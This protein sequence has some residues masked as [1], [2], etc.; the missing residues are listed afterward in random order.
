MKNRKRAIELA[1]TESQ[2]QTR[3]TE[4]PSSVDPTTTKRAW[5]AIGAAAGSALLATIVGPMVAA[6]GD[7]GLNLD[8]PAA[9]DDTAVLTGGPDQNVIYLQPGEQAPAGAPVVRLDP[10]TVVASPRPGSATANPSTKQKVV[11]L[12][13]R[14][15]QTPPPGAIVQQAGA[16]PIV[17]TA[18]T[19]PA[20]SG[21]GTGGTTPKP[22]AT[23][24][25]PVATP[26][27][28]VKPPA[29]ST[30]PSGAP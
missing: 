9:G 30:K 26:A 22:T 23:P 28:T 16:V 1:P 17:T 15:G 8:V 6:S 24:P 3:P 2:E 13:L 20:G 14:P 11:Y 19:P 18:P 29:P 4:R 5:G 27:P 7:G 21:G 25:A 10:I 12:Y